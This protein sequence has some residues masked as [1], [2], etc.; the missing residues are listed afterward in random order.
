VLLLVALEPQ[1]PVVA[2]PGGCGSLIQMMGLLCTGG[3]GKQSDKPQEGET[4]LVTTAKD[5]LQPAL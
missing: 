3:K 2:V 4:A 5:V 1:P